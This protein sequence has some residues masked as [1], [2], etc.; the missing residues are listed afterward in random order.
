M[1]AQ[2]PLKLQ[3]TE[4]ATFSNFYSGDNVQLV[5]TLTEGFE[6]CLYYW[7]SSGVGKTHLLHAACH[8]YM[9]QG[10]RP[11]YLP[12]DNNELVP[13]ML[14]GLEQYDLI[15]LD[16][17]H[18][19]AGQDNWETALFH[20]YN[21]AL[22]NNTCLVISSVRPLASLEVKLADLLSRLGWGLVF[23]LL[24]LND[25]GKQKALQQWAAVRGLEM[26]NEVAQYLLKH[27]PRDMKSLFEILEQLDRASLAAQRKLTIPF[28]RGYIM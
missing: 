17:I 11:V 26:N 1:N 19:V 24:T 3:L 6:G 14:E 28:V 27:C 7:G 5:N 18:A 13:E 2:L 12:L 8:E 15:C 9:S 4:S 10:L 20:L 23:Q 25:D 21:R 16:N 22:E